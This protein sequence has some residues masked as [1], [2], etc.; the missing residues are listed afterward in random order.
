M[1]SDGKDL[2]YIGTDPDGLVYRIN[3]KTK[4]KFVL[5]D[6]A[7]SEVAALALDDKGNLYAATAQT[8]ES[9][10]TGAAEEASNEKT[11]R[12]EAAGQARCRF[13]ASRRR[14]RSRRN[15]PTRIRGNLRPFPRKFSSTS[16]YHGRPERV[17]CEM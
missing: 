6:A 8:E 12:P 13:P 2:L 10:M 17:W 11:G 3:R 7:E 16:A 1:I 14:L 9:G 5:Y 4:E 15:S